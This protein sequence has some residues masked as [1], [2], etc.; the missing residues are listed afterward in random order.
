MLGILLKRRNAE[1]TMSPKGFLIN[2]ALYFNVKLVDH[3]QVCK[4]FL[5]ILSLCSSYGSFGSPTYIIQFRDPYYL[6]K[7]Q[8]IV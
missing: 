6:M 1:A 3:C 8:S 5:S 4:G 2:M 7:L